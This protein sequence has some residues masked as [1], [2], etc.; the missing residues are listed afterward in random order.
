M[1]LFDEFSADTLSFM[2]EFKIGEL[3]VQ[4]GTTLLLEGSNAPQ[5]YTALEGMGLRYKTLESGERQVVNFIFPGDFLGLQAGVMGEMQHSAEASTQMKLCVFDRT[6]LWRLFQ[7]EPSRAYDITWLAAM[8][9]HF[10]G[11]SLATIG[12]REGRERVAWA[13]TRVFLRLRAVQLGN[14]RTVPF[15]FRQQDLADT[16]GMSLV[17]TNKTLKRL[18]NDGLIDWQDGKLSIPDIPALATIAGIDP[19]RPIKRPLL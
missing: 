1:T 11:E 3:N 6:S 5:L 9:E 4:P 2:E 7:T 12:Q 15:S 17:H 14:S 19:E 13:L 8:E 18:R 16:I 10:L